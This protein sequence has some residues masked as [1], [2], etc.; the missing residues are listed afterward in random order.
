MDDLFYYPKAKAQQRDVFKMSWKHFYLKKPGTEIRE[1]CVNSYGCLNNFNINRKNF[2]ENVW[3][4]YQEI[5]EILDLKTK[6]ERYT[7]C[8]KLFNEKFPQP[9]E[10]QKELSKDEQSKLKKLFP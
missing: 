7:L 1:Y 5:E 2:M 9:K 6:Q 3:L 8:D 10:K 4:N